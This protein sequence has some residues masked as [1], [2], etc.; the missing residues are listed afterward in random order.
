MFFRD[1]KKYNTTNFKTIA[2]ADLEANDAVVHKAFSSVITRYFIFRE[3]HPEISDVEHNIL[4]FKLSLDLVAQY[5]M[6]YPESSPTA[7][8]AFQLKLRNYIEEHTNPQEGDIDES[9]QESIEV[10]HN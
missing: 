4:F 9:D 7:L 3:K 5:F 10:Q 6:Q 1:L 2:N 8:Y